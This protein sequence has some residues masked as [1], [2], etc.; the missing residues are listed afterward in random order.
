M[1]H[2]MRAAAYLSYGGDD[3]ESHSELPKKV[4]DDFPDQALWKNDLKD[5]R[6]A[7]NAADY[8]P[9]PRGRKSWEARA[10][11]MKVRADNLIRETRTYLRGQGCT[12]P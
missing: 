11:A 10:L 3:H 9:Y 6:L 1:Y 2:A 5:A 4:P 8:D 12:R 7:R